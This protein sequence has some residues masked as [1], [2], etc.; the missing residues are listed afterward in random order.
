MLVKKYTI[1]KS[2]QFWDKSI[3]RVVWSK[4]YPCI[5]P[6]LN[7]CDYC[8]VCK[9]GVCLMSCAVISSCHVVGIADRKYT[10]IPEREIK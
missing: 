9:S 6:L 3:I 4:R 5:F 2:E 8:G 7:R 1:L 10:Y